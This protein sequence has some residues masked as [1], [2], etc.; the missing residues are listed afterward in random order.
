LDAGQTADGLLAA[1]NEASGN[2]VPQPLTYLIR[3]VERR[4]GELTVAEVGCCLL[5]DD[6]TLLTEVAAHRALGT[7]ALRLLAPGVLASAKPAGPTLELLRANG[8]APVAVDGHGTP[9]LH[10]ITPL[11]ARRRASVV[12]R[13]TVT[14]RYELEPPLD[15]YEIAKSLLAAGVTEPEPRESAAVRRHGEQLSDQEIS[16]LVDALHHE[17]PVEIT[18]LDSNDRGSRRVIT[19]LDFDGDRIEAWCHLRDDERH[20]L[21][22]RIRRVAPA[23]A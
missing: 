13:F 1:L 10:R 3:D 12:P 21:I 8:F 18:Y 17:T 11:R 19:P 22:S 4:H 15:L 23:T 14:R 5:A 6:A 16:L 20:F 9:V 2:D 7:L